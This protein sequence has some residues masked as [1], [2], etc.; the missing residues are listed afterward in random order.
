MIRVLSNLVGKIHLVDPKAQTDDM[1]SLCGNFR[2]KF[3]AHVYDIDDEMFE[4]LR[5]DSTTI[6]LHC[7]YYARRRKII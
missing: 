3:T 1:T 2:P 4:K 6:C 7:L 5:R